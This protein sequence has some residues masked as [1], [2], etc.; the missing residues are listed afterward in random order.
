MMWLVNLATLP[1]VTTTEFKES[2]Y[3][4]GIVLICTITVKITDCA[5]WTTIYFLK[6][7]KARISGWKCW[8]VNF[9]EILLWTL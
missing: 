5:I 6:V 3:E 8:Q 2:A 9:F 4:I 7:Y 1:N